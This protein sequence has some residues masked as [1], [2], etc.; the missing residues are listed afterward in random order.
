MTGAHPLRP[1]QLAT[2]PVK[3]VS[4][5]NAREHFFRK[6]K[7]AKEHR[8]AAALVC[9]AELQKPAL[10][11]VVKLVRISPRPLDLDNLQRSQKSV[12]DGIADWLGIDDRNVALVHYVYDQEKGPPRH[13]GVR[14][15]ITESATVY[16]EVRRVS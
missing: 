11:C 3:T 2:V 13:Y 6:A 16:T 5:S 10:P 7:R 15:E 8:T 1:D 4:E 14:V 12:R 9:A